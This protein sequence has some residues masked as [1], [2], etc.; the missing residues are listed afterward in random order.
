ME[1]QPILITP[2]YLLKFLK[3]KYRLWRGYKLSLNDIY[4]L[5]SLTQFEIGV[6]EQALISNFSLAMPVRG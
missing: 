5:R 3:K 2:S 6:I 1:G 4:M